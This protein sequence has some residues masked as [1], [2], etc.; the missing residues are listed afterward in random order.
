[1]TVK[2]A[3]SVLATA[4]V[5]GA[6]IVVAA[7]DDDGAQG[8]GNPESNLSVAD[9]TKPIDG[10]PPQLAAIREQGNQVLDGGT[11]AF[12]E[13][14]AELEGMPVV[15][16]KWASWCGPCRAEFPH[17][18][19]VASDRGGEIAFLGV[20]SNDSTDAAETFLRELPLPYPSYSDPD[21]DINKEFLDASVAFPATAFYSAG[22]EL[23]YVKLGPYESEAALADDVERY[24]R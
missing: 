24:A 1:M 2:L 20:D 22:G 11:E 7:G 5:L 23:E 17:F 21:Q 4:L 8:P 13:R 16:N 14:L 12:G 15:V 3:I 19:A 10:A 9:A 18:Q 6:V